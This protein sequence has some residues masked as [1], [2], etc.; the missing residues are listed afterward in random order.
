MNRIDLDHPDWVRAGQSRARGYAHL[1]GRFCTGAD[2]ATALDATATDSA[3][4][5]TVGRLNGCFAV[6]TERDGRILAAVD[7]V[8]SIPLFY[9]VDKLDIRLSDSAY[10]L[11]PAAPGTIDRVAAAEFCLTGY[12]TG[13][14]TLCAAVF[15]LEAGEIVLVNP[16]RPVAFERH[17]YHRFRHADFMASGVDDLIAG[18]ENVHA[19]VFRRLAEGIG[20]RTIVV[21]L[22]GGYDSRLI[23]VSLRDMGIRDVICYSYGVPGNWESRT[24][25]ELARYLGF[26]WE[27]VPYSAE[28]W[29]AWAASDRFTA[30]FHSA[31][32]LTSVPHIQD[33]PAVLALQREARIP[34]DSVFVPGHSGDFLAG[35]HIPKSFARRAT[36]TRRELLDSLQR[37]HYSLWD[38]PAETKQELRDEFDR[39]IESI[40]GQIGDGSPE[41]AADA[42]ERWDLQERQAKFICNSVRVYESFGYEWRLPLFDRELMDFWAQI[43][44]DL[45]LGRKLYFEFARQRQSLPVTP[46]NRDHGAVVGAFIRA[47]DRVGL[48]QPEKRAR[49]ALRRLRWRSVRATSPLA[50]LELIDADQFRRTYTGHELMHSY[51]ALRYRDYAGKAI[52][53]SP[54]A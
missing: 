39:R 5:E 15:Q 16:S 7:P 13:R 29:H 21:P 43:P 18:L 28:R 12:V 44:F 48:R 9:A 11:L 14:E 42:F 46:P 10:R 8:R 30:Y 50:W 51:L 19:N 36:V 53:A 40:V 23:G 33:W 2:L 35:S 1:D 25:Q 45:R 26:R 6:I 4:I 27:F 24:S 17:R 52:A 20:G 34:P 49:R 37:A 32:N 38:W 3:W 47:V 22:S 54:Q 31:G 41:E